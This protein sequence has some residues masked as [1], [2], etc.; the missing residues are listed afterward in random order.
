[1]MQKSAS[2]YGCHGH[3]STT[4]EQFIYESSSRPHKHGMRNDNDNTAG[5]A[6]TK[7]RPSPLQ[8]QAGVTEQELELRSACAKL[9]NLGRFKMN[10]GGGDWHEMPFSTQPIVLGFL[11]SPNLHIQQTE[12]RVT[13]DI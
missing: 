4:P 12:T 1:M 5:Q 3:L 8:P 7:P 11:L 9:E 6:K 10:K 13:H 2:F